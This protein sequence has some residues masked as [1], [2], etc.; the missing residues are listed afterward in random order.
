MDGLE[1]QDFYDL[2]QIQDLSV[3]GIYGEQNTSLF[4]GLLGL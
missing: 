3:L 4:Q 1:Q 2:F